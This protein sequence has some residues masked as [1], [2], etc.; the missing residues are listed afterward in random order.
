MLVIVCDIEDLVLLV[1][2]LIVCGGVVVYNV[3]LV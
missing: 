2:V 1:W 3:D